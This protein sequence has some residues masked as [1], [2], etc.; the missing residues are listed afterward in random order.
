LCCLQRVCREFDN[1]LLINSSLMY[2]LTSW[3]L[4]F[5]WLHC[6]QFLFSSDHRFGYLFIYHT[7]PQFLYW[8][9]FV[10]LVFD[11]VRLGWAF[12]FGQGNS[13]LV[14]VFWFFGFRNLVT[15]NV[16]WLSYFVFWFVSVSKIVN[17]LIFEKNSD[18]I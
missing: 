2:V 1:L 17:Q 3:C 8:F 12:G 7:A 13:V 9:W 14:R 11:M 10:S 16:F 6:T 18:P 15:V 4:G 5:S